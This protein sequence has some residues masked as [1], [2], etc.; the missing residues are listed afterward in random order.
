LAGGVHDGKPPPS[1]SE[2]DRIENN[3]GHEEKWNK[4]WKIGAACF[5]TWSNEMPK[6]IAS[7]VAFF[8][9]SLSDDFVAA[10]E[11]WVCDTIGEREVCWAL[12]DSLFFFC[13]MYSMNAFVLGTILTLEDPDRSL[14]TPLL[15]SIRSLERQVDA[16]TYRSMLDF[17]EDILRV[18]LSLLP[19]QLLLSPSTWKR[20]CAGVAGLS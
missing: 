17:R 1:T 2:W 4:A 6:W 3:A 16:S 19:L 15:A 5:V 10:A 13:A 14:E 20:I 7:Y 8:A 9:G 12:F 18:R 11:M